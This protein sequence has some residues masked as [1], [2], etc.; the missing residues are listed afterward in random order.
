MVPGILHGLLEA[1][2]HPL[3]LCVV[4]EDLDLDLVADVEDLARV[5]DSA[6]AHVGD[7]QQAV[8]ATEIDE[9]AVLGDVLDRPLDGHALP[10]R[11]EGLGLELV[12]LLLEQHSAAQNDVAPL[13]VEL[14]DLE[15]E[16][17]PDE[18]VQVSDGPEIHLGARQ[19][20]LHAALDGHR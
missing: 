2:R 12:P 9:G 6:P 7:V 3:G 20:G 14:D 18:A 15:L 19:E 13:L 10:E 5:V 8:D 17:L 1:Q 16:G 11:L 4:L